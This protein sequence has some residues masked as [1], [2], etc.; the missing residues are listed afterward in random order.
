MTTLVSDAQCNGTPLVCVSIQYRV[1][2]FSFGD[3][4]SAK[5]LA[6]LDQTLALEWVQ[7][8]IKG[9]GGDPVTSPIS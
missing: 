5:N 3:E 7:Q 4:T 8:H 2:I 9:F 6:V 1:N